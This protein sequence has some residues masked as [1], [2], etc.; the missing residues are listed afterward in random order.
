MST[1]THYDVYCDGRVTPLCLSLPENVIQAGKIYINS[2]LGRD[3]TSSI[4]KENFISFTEKV[5]PAEVTL[6]AP[7]FSSYEVYHHDL[8]RVAL[9]VSQLDDCHILKKLYL[10]FESVSQSLNESPFYL[11]EVQ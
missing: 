5:D 4:Y 10:A 1:L 3:I 9:M 7:L 6:I 11:E 8:V 2:N